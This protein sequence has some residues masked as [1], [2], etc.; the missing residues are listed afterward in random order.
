[1]PFQT[2][3]IGERNDGKVA[4]IGILDAASPD[5]YR[6]TGA[7]AH[8]QH[9]LEVI[10][11]GFLA[12]LDFL[13]HD[14]VFFGRVEIRGNVAHHI[15]SGEA[16]HFLEAGIDKDDYVAIV[17]DEHTLVERFEEAL[18]LFEPFRSLMI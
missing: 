13:V 15:G 2:G 12:T 16:G 8:G 9:K 3:N 10:P 14:G 11:A 6:E 1:V 7:V 17:G 4:A 18:H 5:D